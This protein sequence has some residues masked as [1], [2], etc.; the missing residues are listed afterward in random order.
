MQRKLGRSNLLRRIEELETRWVDG[1][2]LAP[3]SPAWLEFWQRQVHLYDT[4]QPHVQ[5][6][7]DAVRAIMQASP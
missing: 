5:L 1:S 6:T 3:H 7:L 4:G 2:G